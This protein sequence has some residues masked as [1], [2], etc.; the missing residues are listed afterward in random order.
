[1]AYFPD[2]IYRPSDDTYQ[3][4]NVV[5]AFL[6]ISKH[7]YEYFIEVG[8]GSGY[9]IVN[10]AKLHG[11]HFKRL[12]A[13][14]LNC[15]A[16]KETAKYASDEGLNNVDSVCCNLVDCLRPLGGSLIVFNT[17]YLMCSEDEL[18]SGD[19][20]YVS[21]CRNYRGDVLIGVINIIKSGCCEFILTVSGDGLEF[22][23]SSLRS[24]KPLYFIDIIGNTHMMFEDVATIHLTRLTNLNVNV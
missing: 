3:T 17:P 14:D 15:T 6:R 12:I 5:L 11:S 19:P 21:I 23:E 2:F 7:Q 22:M 24:F 18:S 4:L 20:A 1:M 9:I 16:A 13:T 8:S 10:V